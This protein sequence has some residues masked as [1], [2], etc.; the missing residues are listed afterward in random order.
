MPRVLIVPSAVDC[1]PSE[2]ALPWSILSAAGH[3]I[4]FATT[5]STPPAADDRMLTGRGLSLLAPILQARA[6]AIDAWERMS[7]SPEYRATTS[8]PGLG[9][10]ADDDAFDCVI[11]PGGHA[12]GMRAYL[13]DERVQ[14]L[15][16]M[17]FERQ[18]I[19]GAIC[20]GVIVLARA[21][22]LKGRKT[23]SL[24]KQQERLAFTLTRAW[25][26]D[27]YRTYPA[28]V[29]DEVTAALSSSSDYSEGPMALFRDDPEHLE[30]GFVVEDGNYVSA[31]WPGDAYRFTQALLTRLG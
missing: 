15:A 16:R 26:G 7:R 6:D 20:H 19:V 30:R 25:L 21:G 24:T 13:E 22:V 4:S 31:R 9:V 27:Y 18:K 12:P 3:T 2:V 8:I 28:Y 14:A 29:Q 23:T 5:T 1:D 11:F 10:D 17:A